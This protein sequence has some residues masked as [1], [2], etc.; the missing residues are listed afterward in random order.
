MANSHRNLKVNRLVDIMVV[1]TLIVLAAIAS[2]VFT[3]FY[4]KLWR[5]ALKNVST[6][7]VA[8][9]AKDYAPNIEKPSDTVCA[10]EA[11]Q[12][13]IV[14]SQLRKA[15]CEPTAGPVAQEKH[16]EPTSDLE[17]P[18]PIAA[19]EA[20]PQQIKSVE[21]AKEAAPQATTRATRRRGKRSAARTRATRRARKKASEAQHSTEPQP[22]S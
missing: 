4:K 16:P 3:S 18:A 2:I 7:S 8:E 22:P 5:G 1:T 14:E 17:E 9:A 11:V 21:E 13:P 12:A 15:G 20:A 6:H 19:A 10:V